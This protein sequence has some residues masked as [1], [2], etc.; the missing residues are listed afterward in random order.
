MIYNA[1]IEK[2]LV[3]IAKLPNFV[4]PE[5]SDSPFSFHNMTPRYLKF[6]LRSALCPIRR[7]HVTTKILACL[8]ALV[9]LMSCSRREEWHMADGSVWRTTYHIVYRAPAN[10]NDS[11]TAIFNLVDQSLSPFNPHSRISLINRNEDDDTDQLIDSVFNIACHV[12]LQSHG[13]FDPTVSP[14]VNLWGFGYDKTADISA[15]DLDITQQMIDSALSLTGIMECK[16]NAGKMRKKHP[17]TSFNF[18]AV[19]KGFACDL[20]TGMLRRNGATDL[21]VEIGGEIAVK[22]NNPEG[23]EWRIQIDSPLESETPLH[24]S[25]GMIKITDAGIATSGNYR[26]FHDTRRYGRIGHTIDPTTG[27]P[28][29]TDVA[30][31]TVIAPTAA[32]ADAWAT[33]CMTATADS[34]LAMINRQSGVECLLVKAVADSLITVSSAYFP[35]SATDR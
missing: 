7:A 2:L 22:G 35:T 15:G 17:A 11:I 20:I 8:Y 29:R 16:I 24:T 12:N 27:M 19:T 5:T 10:L 32:L 34:A 28:I 3:S 14:L 18:S 13:K 25:A 30:S 9:F 23:K 31:A 1:K 26:N 21:M 6:P 33:A 4:G